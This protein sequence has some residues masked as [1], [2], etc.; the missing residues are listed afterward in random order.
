MAG[1]SCP[2]GQEPGDLFL[3]D[4]EEFKAEV[5]MRF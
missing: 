2:L 5:S 1:G 4:K 3:E